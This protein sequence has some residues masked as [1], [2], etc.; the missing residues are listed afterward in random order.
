MVLIEKLTENPF[1]KQEKAE[2]AKKEKA[3][4]EKGQQR[5]MIVRMIG[6]GIGVMFIFF[7]LNEFTP[8]K[9]LDLMENMLQSMDPPAIFSIVG[10]RAFPS[11]KEIILALN[12]DKPDNP[13]MS[14][15]KK[16][17]KKRLKEELAKNLQDIEK[18]PDKFISKGPG[19]CGS[20]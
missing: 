11:M 18:S 2:E 16:E 5:M 7:L 4:R 10:S 12:K 1:E 8:I 14:K 9:I 15:L 20:T 6:G 3:E 13:D 19:L 17:E